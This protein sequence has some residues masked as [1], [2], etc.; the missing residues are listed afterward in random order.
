M[1]THIHVQPARGLLD[2]QPIQSPILRR[3]DHHI[4]HREKSWRR[5]WTDDRPWSVD[6]SNQS[7][8]FVQPRRH[9]L[10]FWWIEEGGFVPALAWSHAI[11]KPYSVVR[12]HPTTLPSSTTQPCGFQYCTY[13]TSLGLQQPTLARLLYSAAENVSSGRFDL[14]STRMSMPLGNVGVLLHGFFLTQTTTGRTTNQLLRQA[15]YSHN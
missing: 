9:V 15:S 2:I 12:C 14:D 3:N 1:T 5:D 4:H 8:W 10:T 13:H 7:R 11:Y 6:S